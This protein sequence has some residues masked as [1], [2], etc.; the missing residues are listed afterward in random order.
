MSFH[1]LLLVLQAR[2]RLVATIALAV[3]GVV[4]TIS[5]ILPKQYTAEA[6]VVINTKGM[7]P[8]SGV[9]LQVLPSYM[10]T[11]V[12]IINSDRVAQRVVK[13]LK[14][15]QVPAFRTQW[16]EATKGKGSFESWLGELLNK[17][18]E[19]KPSRESNV[20]NIN[21]K[22]PDAKAAAALANAFT[23]AYI[24]TN[25]DINVEPAKQYATFFTERL[26]VM[27]A[28]VEAA[29]KQLSDFQR[30]NGITAADERLDVESARL[31]ELS[32]QLVAAQSQRMDSAS[33]QQQAGNKNAMSPEVLQNPLI[34]NLKADLSRMESQR[35]EIV[36]RL[37]K[38]HP[39]YQRSEADI[40]ALKDRIAQESARVVTSLGTSNQ[41]NLQREAE[42][43]AALDAQRKKLLLLKN[44]R[45]QLTV[46]Q[47]DVLAAQRAYDTTSQRLTQSSLESQ[48]QQTNIVVLN[49][50]TEPAD[51]S[52][53]K[54][55]LNTLLAIVI[56]AFFAVI[57]ALFAELR[58]QRVRS[59]SE[60]T[61]LLSVPILTN[62]PRRPQ[63][64][65]KFFGGFFRRPA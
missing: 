30:E 16:E 32:T 3:V 63:P 51:P 21:F 40:A 35:D 5:L 54:I 27:R 42:L 59:P 53:P 14:L 43:R 64:S 6:S 9:Q 17:K 10:A 15:D 2:W 39:D 8:I 58:D 41:V 1:Q 29:Q 18:L 37:G 11:Q 24:D 55:W 36:R 46:L 48:T 33:R 19:I 23:Q 56:G 20:I 65:R 50:A 25:L 61:R 34:A 38:N 60:L 7:D 28:D 49:A 44:Q 31:Q 45:D 57:A 52:S 26:K 12:D 13:T 47:N 22:W 62:V 4:V